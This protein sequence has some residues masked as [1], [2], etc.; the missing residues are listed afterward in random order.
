MAYLFKKRVRATVIMLPIDKIDPN[1]NQPRQHFDE[2]QLDI[3]AK[4]ISRNGLLVPITVV[5]GDSGRYTLVAGERRLRAVR[6]LGHTEIAAIVEDIE[7]ER[8]AVLA[9][10]ENL[11]RQDLHYFEEAEAIQR[12][13]HELDVPQN[14]VCALLGVSQPAI[15]NKLRLLRLSKEVRKIAVENSFPERISRALVRL[16]DEEAQL[17][18]AK[19]I[20]T[21]GYGIAKAEELVEQTLES[22]RPKPCRRLLTHDYRVIFMAVEELVSEIR[23]MGASVESKRAETKSYYE[24][25]VRVKK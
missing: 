3:L 11:H 13:T 9:L 8:S 6:M 24:Y 4:S 20:A 16:E 18:T 10:V 2:T 17:Q 21:K 12:L 1:P 22:Q 14:K 19:T 23:S 5:K 15:S 25:T 7:Q